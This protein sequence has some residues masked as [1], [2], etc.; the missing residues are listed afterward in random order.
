MKAL[1]IILILLTTFLYSASNSDVDIC[2][3]KQESSGFCTP[4]IGFKCKTST[5]LNIY[6]SLDDIE[7]SKVLT[8]GIGIGNFSSYLD[9]DGAEKTVDI[10]DDQA[11]KQSQLTFSKNSTLNAS[12]FP[13]GII[14]RIGGATNAENNGHMVSGDTTYI[15]DEALISVGFMTN[16][17]FVA[18]YKKDGVEYEH[19]LKECSSSENTKNIFVDAWDKDGSVNDR[20][21]TTKV[22][23][24]SFILSINQLELTQHKEFEFYL[25]DNISHQI[26]Q[27]TTNRF[28][29]TTSY[30]QDTE[31]KVDKA[32]KDVNVQFKVCTSTYDGI[33]YTLEDYDKCEDYTTFLF[34]DKFREF[35]FKILNSTDNFAI[36]PESFEVSG[37]DTDEPEAYRHRLRLNNHY[38]LRFRAISNSQPTLNYDESNGNS[39]EILIGIDDT[40]KTCHQKKISLEAG[41]GFSKGKK[42]IDLASFDV[43]DWNVTMRE[44]KGYEFA[45]VDEDDNISDELL[46]IKPYTKVFTVLPNRFELTYRYRNRNENKHFTYI[47]SDINH[48]STLTLDIQALKADNTLAKNYTSTC[49]AKDFNLSIGYDA[50]IPTN[51]IIYSIP[52]LDKNATV[53]GEF[54][55]KELSKTLFNSDANAS[56]DIL[57]NFDRNISKAVNPFLFHINQVSI[58]D[59]DNIEGDKTQTQDALFIYGRTHTARETFTDKN[60]TSNIYFEV[61]CYG[62]GC[63]KSLLQ[64]STSPNLKYTNDIRWFINENHDTSTDGKAGSVSQ[65]YGGGITISSTT[66]TNPFKVSFKYDGIYGYPYKTTMQNSASSWLIYNQDD[67]SAT[68]NT[69]QIEFIKIGKWTGEH[70]TD[71]TTKDIN[72]STNLKNLKINKRTIW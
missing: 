27:N 10:G 63:D 13:S 37:V 3:D 66:D 54:S 42:E 30:T 56:F 38:R 65:K 64:N 12:I 22:A 51:N 14:Y 31:F 59:N 69:F 21:I 9:I 5:Y 7:V 20:D 2:I 67:E 18:K 19:I 57:I 43:G 47:S 58:V 68:D 45:K 60:G 8:N 24:K 16:Y 61:Y 6:N 49:Y 23:S 62:A 17:V 29:Q 39:F 55:I 26:I 72:S 41:F 52:K 46:Y 53:N 4:I 33:N 35:N 1:M 11:E 44:R 70:Q 28:N 50:D 32:Y 25:Y 40:T 15:T 71:T 34:E 36:R 48:S